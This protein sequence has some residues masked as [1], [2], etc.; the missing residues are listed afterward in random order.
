MRSVAQQAHESVRFRPRRGAHIVEVERVLEAGSC[1]DHVAGQLNSLTRGLN[2]MSSSGD[3]GV[4]AGTLRLPAAIIELVDE[5]GDAL[6]LFG[7]L[8]LPDRRAPRTLEELRVVLHAAGEQRPVAFEEVLPDEDDPILLWPIYG[9]L[10]DSAL[11]ILYEFDPDHGPHRK[12]IPASVR[13]ILGAPEEAAGDA[14]RPR[15]AKARHDA[16]READHDRQDHSRPDN[17]GDSR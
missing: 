4:P 8:Q 15:R 13:D 3:R 14:G 1:L 6:V 7:Q 5:C 10:L 2:D 16:S 9:S 11:R 12:A 17:H